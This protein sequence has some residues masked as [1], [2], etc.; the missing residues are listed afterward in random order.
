[1]LR[2]VVVGV[3]L[4]V[5]LHHSAFALHTTWTSWSWRWKQCDL[6]LCQ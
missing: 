5:L 1:M 3:V 4:D 2:C 6:S